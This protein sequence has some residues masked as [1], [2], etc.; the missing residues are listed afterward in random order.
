MEVMLGFLVVCLLYVN[1]WKQEIKRMAAIVPRIKI[2]RSLLK[3][4]VGP[5]D[6]VS[7]GLLK[8]YQ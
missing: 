1:P 6:K 7:A 2:G 5:Q 4:K 3:L 8:S